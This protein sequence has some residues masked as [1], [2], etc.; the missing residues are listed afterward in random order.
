MINTNRQSHLKI[1]LLFSFFIFTAAIY[2]SAAAEVSL[3]GMYSGFLVANSKENFEVDGGEDSEESRGHLKGKLGMYLNDYIS[4]EGQ[5]G[6][7]NNSDNDLV[8]YGAYVRVDKD[9]GNYKIYGLLGASGAESDEDVSESSGSYG[10]GMEIFGSK[11]VAITFEYINMIEK[12]VEGGDLRLDSLGIGFTYYFSDET[13]A[14]VK[15]RNKIRSIR[16]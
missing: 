12:S 5:L 8:T 10:L 3:T 13:S 7:T 11:D 9:F 15:N 14:F 4:V 6:F 1:N 16:Y 2:N